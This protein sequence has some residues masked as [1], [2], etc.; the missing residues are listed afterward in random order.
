MTTTASPTFNVTGYG[1]NVLYPQLGKTASSKTSPKKPALP[2]AA[3]KRGSSL[4][5]NYDRDGHLDLS[6]R[7]TS[8]PT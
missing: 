4:G 7:A 2:A 3:F 8:T 6:F 1:G 5:A